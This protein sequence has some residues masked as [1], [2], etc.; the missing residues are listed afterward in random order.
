MKPAVPLKLCS[1]AF[2]V[3]WTCGMLWSSGEIDRANVIILSI[4][5]ALAGVGVHYA[6]H[7]VFQYT[8]LNPPCDPPVNPD[9]DR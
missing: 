9:R 2:A 6:M 1:I 3:L 7:W 8:H 5:G 4:C